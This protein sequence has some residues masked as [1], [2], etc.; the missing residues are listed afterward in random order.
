MPSIKTLI[1]EI[2]ENGDCHRDDSLLD[3]S[4]Y[5]VL[6]DDD[7]IIEN[8]TSPVLATAEALSSR[9]H[10]PDTLFALRAGR[11]DMV[12]CVIPIE[13]AMV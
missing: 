5:R 10:A 3:G 7:Q 12:H 6:F 8:T 1:C 4:T 2:R 9:G 13:H 11:G